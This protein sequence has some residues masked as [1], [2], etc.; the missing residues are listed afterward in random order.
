MRT[1]DRLGGGVACYPESSDLGSGLRFRTGRTSSGR[2]V[3][4]TVYRGVAYRSYPDSKKPYFA[5]RVGRKYVELHRVVWGCE[6]GAIPDGF[7]IHH[8]DGNPANNDSA[9]LECLPAAEHLRL[10]RPHFAPRQPREAE[11]RVCGEKYFTTQVGRA[12]A[13]SRR[14]ANRYQ[15]RQ[16][17]KDIYQLQCKVCGATFVCGRSTQ[18]YCSI[19]CATSVI[20]QHRRL[21]EKPCGWCGGA[22]QPVTSARRFCSRR[23]GVFA[24]H[25]ARKA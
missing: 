15:Y 14:C 9:N 12:V 1:G 2:R 11:C 10:H 5:T 4:V 25:A 24:G 7:H 17:N 22:F 13:C 21:P 16:G 20:Q 18:R 3:V 23:C 8:V 19:S 6:R